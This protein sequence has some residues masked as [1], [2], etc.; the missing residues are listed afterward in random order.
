MNATNIIPFQASQY[1]FLKAEYDKAHEAT[2]QGWMTEIKAAQALQDSKAWKHLAKTWESYCDKHMPYRAS[3][4][5]N[6]R[7]SIPIAE[8][9]E[10]VASATVSEGQARV[11]REKLH[12]LVPS[13]ER[14][15]VP[16][17]WQLA[18]SYGGKINPDKDVLNA[19]YKVLKEERDNH[20]LSVNGESYDMRT[21][22]QKEAIKEALLDNIQSHAPISKKAKFRDISPLLKLLPEIATSDSAKPSASAKN[23]RLIWDEE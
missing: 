17:L 7:Q 1:E 20:S 2:R 6:Y 22:G 9:I 11:I 23:F 12:E 21:L 4:Y 19:A 3:T 15:I 18:Y 8:L 14:D 16:S 10:T 13:D 5:K